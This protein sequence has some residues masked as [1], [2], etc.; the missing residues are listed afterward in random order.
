MLEACFQRLLEEISKVQ[1]S[2]VGS[3]DEKAMLSR[4]WEF[5]YSDWGE[6]VVIYCSTRNRPGGYWIYPM[7]CPIANLESLKEQLPEYS[8]DQPSVAYDHVSSG[9]NHWIEPCWGKHEDFATSE[10]PLFFARQY[11]GNPKGKENYIE[12]SQMVTHP[13]GLHW[14]ERLNSY[15]S[16]DDYG[17]ETEKIK[18]IK[19]DDVNL[20]L[21]SRR[22]LDKLLHLGDWVLVRYTDF[23]RF[24]SKHPSFHSCT[25]EVFIPTE[26]EGK[27]EIRKCDNDYIEFRGAQIE[28]PKSSKEQLLSWGSSDDGEEKRYADFS[29][30]DWKNKAILKDYSL[31]PSNYA[32]YFTKSDLP[33]ETSHIFFKAEVL[34]KYKNNPDK[35][36]LS[37]RTI[38]C[39]GGWYLETYDI[40]E[41]NQVH[42]YAIYLGRL[43]YKEQLHW[44][45]YNEDPKGPIAKRAYLTDFEA[46]FPDEIPKLDQLKQSLEILGSLKIGEHGHIIWAPKGGSWD[47]AFRGLHYV[48]SENSNQWHD[49]VI[50]LANAT[51]EG[52]IVKPLKAIAK[53]MGN[54]DKMLG[55]LGL[56]RFILEASNNNE[57]IPVIHGVLSDLQN[58]R[59]QGKAHGAWKTPEGS[60]IKDANNRLLDVVLA[61]NELYGVFKNISSDYEQS[62][63]VNINGNDR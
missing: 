4:N 61:I 56:I 47:I 29:V 12:F 42:T 50:A 46:K 6:W 18:L 63:G 16:I 8:I 41:L 44:L 7:L 25:S 60:L 10:I 3:T 32:N 27:F 36:D 13:L 38:E 39:K 49:Y 33:F 58:C 28:H 54:N 19:T 21:F 5:I 51:N 22:T 48:H 55:S 52:F 43:P 30:Y 34:D 14:S 59:S 62:K 11:Y 53:C 23:N 20:I 45:Q 24:N 2:H 35:Y 37:E 9:T 26:Y 1:N 17:E 57:K 15:C 31:R 40:N